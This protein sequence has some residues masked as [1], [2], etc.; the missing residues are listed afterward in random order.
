MTKIQKLI[1]S[2]VIDHVVR[3][4]TNIVIFIPFHVWMLP[5]SY[6]NV[7]I[8]IRLTVLL[9]IRRYPCKKLVTELSTSISETKYC[10]PPYRQSC[11]SNL[12]TCIF[13]CCY[14][15]INKLTVLLP[16]VLPFA[17]FRCYRNRINPKSVNLSHHFDDFLNLTLNRQRSTRTSCSLNP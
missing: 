6:W 11:K 7:T 8:K 12:I 3:T 4:S 5:T 17:G 1:D 15:L 10:L 14:E 2:F 16:S 13:Y 9:F